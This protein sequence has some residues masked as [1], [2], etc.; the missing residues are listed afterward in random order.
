M[1]DLSDLR[2]L[3]SETADVS[4]LQAGAMGQAVTSIETLL[5]LFMQRIDDTAEWVG[6]L[7]EV[8]SD[9]QIIESAWG[10]LAAARASMDDIVN[11]LRAADAKAR[12]AGEL[13][14]NATGKLRGWGVL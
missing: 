6:L 8:A 5:A 13:F 14:L 9:S 4:A 1:S 10:D 2:R 12:V 11:T 3:V 7:A